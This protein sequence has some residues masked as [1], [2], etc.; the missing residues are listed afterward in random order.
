MWNDPSQPD[1]NRLNAMDDISWSYLAIQPDSAI[2]FAN[3]M[4]D[5]AM[6]TNNPKW[7]AAGLSN[8]G[9]GNYYLGN[10]A[11]SINCYEKAYEIFTTIGNVKSSASMI[12]YMGT[13]YKGQGHYDKAMDYFDRSYELSLSVDDVLG[14]GICH[15]NMGDICFEKGDAEKAMDEYLVTLDIY[16]E[17]DD[18]NGKAGILLRIAEIYEQRGDLVKA[19]DHHNQALTIY[20]AMGYKMGEAAS[21]ITV[22][23]IY[24]QLDATEKA[25]TFYEKAYEIFNDIGYKQGIAAALSN[26]AINQNDSLTTKKLARCLSI[27]KELGDIEN[28]AKLLNNIGS[29]DW[30]QGNQILAMERY[31]ESLDLF[32][33]IDNKEGMASTMISIGHSY[34]NLKEYQPCISMVSNAYQIA[35]EVGVPTQIRESAY[36]LFKALKANNQPIKALAMHEIYLEMEDSINSM[37]NQE[38]IIKLEY[39]HEYEKQQALAEAQHQEELALA[40][41]R[42]KIQQLKFYAAGGGLALVLVI[43]FLIFNRLRVTR[44][45]KKVI[46]EQ[47]SLVEE[48]KKDI[49]D[50]IRYG[51]NIQQA[52]LPTIDDL[53]EV[54][55][56]G[57]VLFQPKDIVSGDF[58][59]LQHHN[60]RVYLAVCD[61]TGHGV[62]GAFMS[63]IGSSLL[64]EA[65]VEKG[66]TQP[67]EIFFEVRKGIINALKQTEDYSSQKDG[68][69]AALIAWDKGAAL[70]VASAYNPV[71]IIRN[72]ELK[73]IKPDKQPVGFLTGKQKE[74]THHE[75][76]LEKGDTVYMFSDG[77]HDQFGGHKGKKF[78]LAKFK[79]LLLSIQDNTMNEQRVILED[80]MRK[81]K[82]ETEQVDDILV[83]GIRF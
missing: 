38:A 16:T 57:F 56:D 13:I 11:I 42:E 73:E 44:R 41:E 26:L 62:P 19:I 61:C 34:F 22:G 23:N 65:V 76:A 33:S 81:W 80:T 27:Y 6:E 10:Y 8:K 71:L 50:S 59:W 45:Q 15:Q 72:G 17:L 47:K 52:L 68:M 53:K 37:E 7:I 70:Q 49:T 35:Q 83:M 55:P 43:A 54:L 58:Y 32:T 48:Q 5:F 51:E 2:Y 14:I 75:V 67:N 18:Q 69:D 79:K 78:K 31:R 28:T 24:I 29:R 4:H 30:A 77:Y 74:F 39:Q 60:D 9:I 63:M 12:R 1:T 3:L 25:I 64:D 66:I 46:E 82:G 36:V 20:N 40:V 21:Y